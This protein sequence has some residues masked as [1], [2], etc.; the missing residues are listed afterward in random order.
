MLAQLVQTSV[1]MKRKKLVAL[2]TE[3]KLN[4]ATFS[5]V[6]VVPATRKTLTSIYRERGKLMRI[7]E[8]LVWSLNWLYDKE[9]RGACQT[10]FRV[11]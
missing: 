2:E 11:L 5:C 8:F 4:Y 10:T 3:S 6:L 7:F 9:L 1:R